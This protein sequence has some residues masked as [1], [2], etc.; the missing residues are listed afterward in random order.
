[1]SLA[2][3]PPRVRIEGPSQMRMSMTNRSVK[4]YLN[5]IS[6]KGDEE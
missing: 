4:T 6:Q 3:S 2:K 5:S 1:M